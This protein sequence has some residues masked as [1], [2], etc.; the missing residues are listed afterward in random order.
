MIKERRKY[1]RLEKNIPLKVSSPN[2]DIVTQTQNISCIGAYCS[3][4]TDLPLMTKLKVTL[5]LPEKH[6]K[7]SKDK[8][9]KVTCVGVVVRSQETCE[10]G[11]YD[12]AIFFEQISEKE[13][14]KLEEYI[15]HHLSADE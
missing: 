10:K 3:I 9:K 8:S 1:P 15:N 14:L 11:I 5:L 13:R 6:R 7:S 2:V 12:A 4:N